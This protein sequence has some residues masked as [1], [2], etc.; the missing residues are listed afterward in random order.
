MGK[1]PSRQCRGL[2]NSFWKVGAI[3]LLFLDIFLLI[4]VYASAKSYLA[5]VQRPIVET[6]LIEKRVEVI[7]EKV[8]YIN[9]K[10]TTTPTATKTAQK[11]IGSGDC[12]EA[13]KRHFPESQWK[14][15]SAII[16]AESGGNPASVSKTNDHGCFQINK[17]LQAYGPKI[18]EAD[19]NAYIAYTAKYARHGW[20][21][22]TTAK[23]LGL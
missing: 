12:Y 23:K 6:K 7:R 18:Y 20:K 8:I 17:G 10:K 2:T 15:A 22:W 4:Q 1:L 3:F 9:R 14:N 16:T 21:P 5:L 19:F 13:M 11:A